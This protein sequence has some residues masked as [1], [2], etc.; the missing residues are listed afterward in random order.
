MPAPPEAVD[1]LKLW[2]RFH[3]RLSLLYGTLVLAV[4]LSVTAFFY[5]RG[6]ASERAA[7][8]ARLRI[9]ATSLA[10]AIA[11]VPSSRVSSSARRV[12][13]WMLA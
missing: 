3:I 13:Q 11:P 7:L 2:H 5:V 6:V 12:D 10:A 4:L 9:G 1:G 8:A